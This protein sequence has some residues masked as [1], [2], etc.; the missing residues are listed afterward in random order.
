M[1]HAQFYLT[2]LAEECS[3]VSQR[4]LKQIQFGK[5]ES[6]SV[7]PFNNREITEEMKL[8]NAQRLREEVNHLLAV[9]EVLE[10][11]GE[12]PTVKQADLDNAIDEKIDKMYQYKRY[13]VSLGLVEA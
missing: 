3:E 4:A 1:N 5:N 7:N 6:Q 10:F 11:I 2:K 12:L 13:S 9:V 8:T